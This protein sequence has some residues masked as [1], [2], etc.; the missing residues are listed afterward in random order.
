MTKSSSP[1]RGLGRRALVASALA[2]VSAAR[3]APVYAA[4]P[5]MKVAWISPQT[6]FLSS[7][8]VTDRYVFETLGPRFRSGLQTASGD[9]R[10]VEISLHDA[11]SS[12]EKAAKL[13][14]ELI[15]SGVHLILTTATPEICNPVSDAC[16]AAG[17]PCVSSIVPWQAWYYGR[18]ATATK[19]FEWTYHFFAG[20][21]DFADIY[22]ALQASANLGTKTGGLFGD[23][24]DAEAFLKAFP[25]AFAKRGI[26]LVVPQR[27][28]FA[29]PDWESVAIQLRDANIRMVTG[30]LPPPIA[31]AFFQAADKVG[32]KPVMASIAKAFAFNDTVAQIQR[33]G[34]TLTNEVWWSPAWPFKSSFTGQTAAKVVAT[35]EES[36]GAPWVQTLGFSHALMEVAAHVCQNTPSTKAAD[37]RDTL[38]RARVNTLAGPINWRDSHPNR[39]VCTTPA[40]GGQWIRNA[41]GRWILEVVDNTRSPVIPTTAQLTTG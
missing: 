35:Y 14:T 19:G 10:Q 41:K 26:E 1:A 28:Q 6:G 23:D 2:A 29:N 7:F 34:L 39:N 24:I 20:L 13:A 18:G 12:P 31:A 5:A 30:V 21:E 22:S 8:G 32:Y 27:V 3:W 33:P 11:A 25:P 16:E 4:A 9:T 38:K 15:A 17:V 40:V 36:T 37:V